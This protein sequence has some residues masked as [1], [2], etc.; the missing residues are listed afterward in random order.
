MPKAAYISLMVVTLSFGSALASIPVSAQP[1][2]RAAAGSARNASALTGPLA[3][4][5]TVRDGAGETLGR[6]TRLTTGPNGQT[7]VML[8]KGV[9]SFSV[10]ANVLRISGDGVISSLS[11]QDIKA[12]GDSAAH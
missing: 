12:L 3:V 6:I 8:R 10:P 7:L 2:A 5:A 11:R 4:G 1:L 9:D